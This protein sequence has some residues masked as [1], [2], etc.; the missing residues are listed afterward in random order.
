M[1]YFELL[2]QNL[3]CDRFYVVKKRLAFSVAF[4]E[5]MCLSSKITSLLSVYTNVSKHHV[6]SL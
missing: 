3:V 6:D 5:I 4:S 1:S 2:K